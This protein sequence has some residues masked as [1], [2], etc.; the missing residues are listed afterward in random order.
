MN[1]N[2]NKP[3]QWKSDI[4]QSVDFYNNWF[5][6]FAP[7]AYRDTRNK[8]TGQVEDALIKTN[9]LLKIDPIVLTK[10]PTV[11]AI[12]R[13]ATAPP[14]ARDRLIGLAGVSPTLVKSMEING[15]I[16]PQM[17][18]S[19]ATTGLHKIG[20]VIEKLLDKDMFPW[21]NEKR[22][23]D[24]IESHRASTIIADR[25]CG[26][27]ADPIIRNAQEKRQLDVIKKWLESRGYRYVRSGEGL[28]FDAMQPSTFAFRLNIP[29][30]LEASKKKVNIP[31]DVAITTH[32]ILKDF[33]LNSLETNSVK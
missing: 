17:K 14:I 28:K 23:P 10:N 33:K 4:A 24:K 27:V 21:Y 30:T 19:D 12:L 15:R 22:N 13:M 7:K 26:S 5:M 9:H 16:P 32:N 11:L 20:H 8:T 2:S 29:V 18:P 3:Q 25:L 6:K 31:V 1:I